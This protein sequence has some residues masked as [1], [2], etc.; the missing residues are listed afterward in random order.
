VPRRL[1]QIEV[2]PYCVKVRTALDRLGLDYHSVPIDPGDRS[3]VRKLSGQDKVPVLV[4]DTEVIVDS[5]R[6]FRHLVA[7][8]NGSELLPDDPWSRSLAWILEGYADEVLGPLI[9]RLI[10]LDL[11]WSP[12]AAEE[13]RPDA[14]EARWLKNELFAEMEHL[15]SLLAGSDYVLGDSPTLADLALH[16]FLGCLELR[17]QPPIPAQ[18]SRLRSWYAR[19]KA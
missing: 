16:A 15:E 7:R 9:R 10:N 1:L 14:A 6:I 12:G 2:C 8:Y 19:M 5:T 11:D 13:G 18:F 17:A 4:D 3:G